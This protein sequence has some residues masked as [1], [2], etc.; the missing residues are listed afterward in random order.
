M[1]D[2][3]IAHD[4]EIEPTTVPTTAEVTTMSHELRMLEAMLFAATEPVDEG[5]LAERLPEGSDVR[6]LLAD[7]ASQYEGRGVQLFHVAGRW[8]FRTADDL[9]G[10]LTIERKVVRKL[11]RASVETLSII[12]YHQPIT[13]GEIEEIRGVALSKG[14]L[15]LL[16][17]IG[18]IRPVGRRRTPGRPV[19][20]GTSTDFLDQFGLNSLSDLP[21]VDELKAAGLLDSRPVT[22]IL[23]EAMGRDMAPADAGDREDEAEDGEGEERVA[24][25]MDADEIEASFEF[26]DDGE[27]EAQAEAEEDEEAPA[28]RA[29][30]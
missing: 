1:M 6:A 20:W 26:E 25:S 28:P 10:S 7:L 29:E 18:W 4:A 30:G 24:G 19:T 2:G 3:S 16:L 22:T 21:G 13:R 27:A 8:A 12:A 9:A 15:D 11:S 17:E 23:G 14:T 5:S